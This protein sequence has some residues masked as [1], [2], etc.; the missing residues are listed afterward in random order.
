MF[1]KQRLGLLT[2]AL[3]TG[4]WLFASLSPSPARANQVSEASPPAADVALGS[5][6]RLRGTV[7]DAQGAPLS[8]RLVT[9]RQQGRVVTEV[10]TGRDGRFE[11]QG[12]EGG[13][14]LVEC[15]QGAVACRLWTAAAAP[16]AARGE[17]LL[18]A[19]ADVARGQNRMRT[20]VR[21]A[22]IVTAVGAAI[23][24]PI[25]LTTQEEERKN[26]S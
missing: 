10:P 18:P 9:L 22:A 4:L 12:L 15:E 21:T 1:R 26:G 8:G 19:T 13:T 23:A 3:S 5:R 16:P 24:I 14:Y 11:V 20:L 7:V 6:G 2:A 17:L 25:V